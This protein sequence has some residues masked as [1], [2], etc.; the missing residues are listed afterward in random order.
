MG[1]FFLAD[2]KQVLFKMRKITQLD[3][4]TEHPSFLYGKKLIKKMW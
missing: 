2:T 4:I 1:N 3:P